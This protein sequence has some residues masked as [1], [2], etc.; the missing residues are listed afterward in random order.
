M[1]VTT[2]T[3]PLEDGLLPL[4]VAAKHVGC[5]APT[6]RGYIA[7][8]E[9]PAYRLSTASNAPLRVRLS[10]VEKLLKPA[11]TQRPGVAESTTAAAGSDAWLAE[12]L[13]RF[14]AD[15]FRRAGELLLALSSASRSAA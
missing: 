8:G 5:S 4:S 1:S 12:T 10:D 11:V 3:M 7:S 2:N 13:A 6:L 14:T 9:L 15:D